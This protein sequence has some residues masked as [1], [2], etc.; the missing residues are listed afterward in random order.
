MAKRAI[1][2]TLRSKGLM[3]TFLNSLISLLFFE[4]SQVIAQVDLINQSVVALPAHRAA[5]NTLS[6]LNG[7]KIGAAGPISVAC[8]KG[9]RR[10]FCKARLPITIKN[11]NVWG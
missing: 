11:G 1:Y 2:G 8:K 4:E 9:N 7:I 10:G 5:T 3:K 6:N